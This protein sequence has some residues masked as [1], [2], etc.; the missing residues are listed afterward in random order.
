MIVSEDALGAGI[1][2]DAVRSFTHVDL[3]D[4]LQR[5]R[6]EHRDFILAAVAG[7]P[8]LE[9]RSERHAVNSR[10]IRDRSDELTGVGVDHVHLRAV[11]KVETPRRAIDRY[12]VKPTIPRNR[13]A[14]LNLV[15]AAR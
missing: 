4:E 3:V 6:I 8:M 12:I 11:R 9:L 2:V 10:R 5:R 7:E 1:V 14:R 13:V 15:S